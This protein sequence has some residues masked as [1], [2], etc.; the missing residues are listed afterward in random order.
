MA[1]VVRTPG[2]HNATVV[3][4]RGSMQLCYAFFSANGC[5]VT[6]T[7]LFCVCVS[8]HKHL[9]LWSSSAQRLQALQAART[10]RCDL[11]RARVH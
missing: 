6:L 1:E 7:F 5:Y 8:V 2:S 11:V 4:I 3:Y 9:K 10:V